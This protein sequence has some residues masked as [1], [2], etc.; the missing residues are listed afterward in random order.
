MGSLRQLVVRLSVAKHKMS[1]VDQ[2]APDRVTS[3]MHS[4]TRTVEVVEQGKLLSLVEY[5]EKFQS[6]QRIQ[7]HTS[8]ILC[9]K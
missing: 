7:S 5:K 4:E 9:V 8:D 2:C 6:S 3:N 1:V